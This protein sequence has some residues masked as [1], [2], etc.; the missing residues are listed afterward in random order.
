MRIDDEEKMS[1]TNRFMSNFNE[2]Q[3][4]IKIK[5][6]PSSSIKQQ[7]HY[8]DNTN[9]S[10]VYNSQ[11]PTA[12]TILITNNFNSQTNNKSLNGQLSGPSTSN[13]N[14]SSIT[15]YTHNSDS[16]GGSSS[17]PASPGGG[18]TVVVDR[19]NIL[20][21]NHFNEPQ[22]GQQQ[23]QM[24]CTTTTTTTS[25]T[26]SMMTK[27]P[28]STASQHN[29]IIDKSNEIIPKNLD[30]E[31]AT[32]VEVV[33][34]SSAK[35]VIGDDVCVLQKDERFYVGTIVTVEQDQYLVRL[36]DNSERWSTIAELSTFNLNDSAPVCVVCKNTKYDTAPVACCKLCRRGYH[37]KCADA[38]N[39]I[40]FCRRYVLYLR[41]FCNVVNFNTFFFPVATRI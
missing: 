1:A 34:T 4:G 41:F 15:I 2:G 17:I 9:M 37:Y 6:E 19:I 31:K 28:H 27:I 8:D 30:F 10:C 12:K 35:Y 3:Q 16:E 39:G 20:I 38:I 22:S 33:A 11:S 32:I 21:N 18:S 40:W 13:M 14:K 29:K 23:P 7:Q 24:S 36:R 25:D 5:N 26:S